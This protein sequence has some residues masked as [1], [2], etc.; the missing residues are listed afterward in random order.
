M[1]ESQLRRLLAERSPWRS[2]TG[3]EAEDPD[4]RAAR[5]LPLV[6]EP[7]P[8]ADIGAPGLYVLRGPRRIGKSLEL[9]RAITGLLAR[10]VDPKA[11]LYCSCDGLSRQ[12][13]RRL[14][15]QGQSVTRMLPGPR[16][17][18]LDEITAVAGWS[19][20]IKELRDQDTGF[21]EAC[22]VLTGSSA[23][24]LEQARK[25]LA[26]RRGGAADSERLLL[27][28]GFRAFC[29][30]LG[31]LGELPEQSVA[32][33]DIQSP[34]SERA[35]LALEP[36]S[37]ALANAWE[38]FLDVGG[39]PRAVGEF[40]ATGTVSDG[41]VQGLWDVV[42]GDAFRAASLTEAAVAALLDR[43]AANLCSPINLSRIARDVGLP[44]YQAAQT[45]IEGLVRAFLAWHC[46]RTRQDGKPNTSAQRKLYF[47][48]PLIAQ[49]SHRHNPIYPVPDAAK[50]TEQQI[51]LALAGAIRTHAPAA[52]LQTEA[53][54]YER[55]PTGAEIDYVGPRLGVA[56]GC[57][58]TDG[59]WRKQAL[60]IKARHGRGVILTRS[61]LLTGPHEPVW[62]LPASI[63]AWLIERG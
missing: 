41:F 30:A 56:F 5:K 53:V 47:V 43:L 4:L 19:T 58:Y 60:T 9:K 20:T 54:M 31:D 63:L 29:R 48:D 33:A 46:H 35:I 27:P 32:P 11:V 7:A 24:D 28:M 3:W 17:W 59:A 42:L 13:L 55:T 16:Y 52:F 44:G 21:R 62:A 10:G 6:Y 8:L 22:V 49:L 26:D 2:R 45:R 38:L 61:P 50:L 15:V 18:F 51:G 34:A 23:H 25:D 57:K 14:I 39:F 37:D 12:E 40:L 1:N 36:S